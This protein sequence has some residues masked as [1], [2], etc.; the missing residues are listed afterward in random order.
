MS[1]TPSPL[2]R[3]ISVTSLFPC[4]IPLFL[5]DPK[6]MGKLVLM[7]PFAITRIGVMAKGVQPMKPI[8]Y[9]ARLAPRGAWGLAPALGQSSQGE[10][11]H[12]I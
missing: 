11:F 10:S 7:C 1:E 5:A 3:S 8:V 9:N 6:G 4:S 2:K 12:G